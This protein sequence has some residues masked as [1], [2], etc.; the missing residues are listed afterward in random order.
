MSE[1]D[2]IQN[3]GIANYMPDNKKFRR[4]IWQ[5]TA[6]LTLNHQSNPTLLLQSQ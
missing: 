5:A 2:F 6:K 1:D 3:I 4:S